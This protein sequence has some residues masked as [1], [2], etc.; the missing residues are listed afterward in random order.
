MR[1]IKLE[2]PHCGASLEVNDGA[3]LV[4]C[5]Y[6]G[7]MFELTDDVTR[8]EHTVNIKDE[9]KLK[10]AQ[11]K[12]QQYQDAQ[13]RERRMRE[14]EKQ[15]CYKRGFAGKF[16]IVMIVFCALGL[17]AA[18]SSG[19][20]LAGIIAILQIVLLVISRLLATGTLKTIKGFRIPPV[21]PSLL[22]LLLVFPFSSM[23]TAKKA[24]KL[25]WPNTG[26]ASH[27]PDPSAK[28]GSIA[29][30]NSS[31]FK[32]EVDKYSAKQCS[33]YAAACREQGFTEDTQHTYEFQGYDAEGY[34]ISIDYDDKDQTMEIRAEAPL[35]TT[36]LSW[37]ISDLVQEL[38]APPSLKG[39]IKTESNDDVEVLLTGISAAEAQDY[40][41]AV[42]TTSFGE[43]FKLQDGEL[44]AA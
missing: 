34:T 35:E 18:F 37:P 42:K 29:Y 3:E 10:E 19:H 41:N 12:E 26:I 7:K 39:V 13:E 23:Y 25:T 32:A 8:T 33:D 21:I 38:P 36:E 9:A 17:F 28:Y 27:I 5:R 1:L 24:E 43:N 30:N 44:T 20:I 6:C 40:M 22:A 14:A 2:C 11:L 16:N 31:S 15:E 4:T